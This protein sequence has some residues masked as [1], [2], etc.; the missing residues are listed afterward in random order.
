MHDNP[1]YPDL[2]E[3]VRHITKAAVNPVRL[4]RYKISVIS[5][6]CSPMARLIWR[7]KIS[8]PIKQAAVW[9]I[10]HH[11]QV[12]HFEEVRLVRLLRDRMVEEARRQGKT[13]EEANVVAQVAL[14]H[15]FLQMPYPA[16]HNGRWHS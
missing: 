11:I 14:C 2:R 12:H 16:P 8:P 15:E 6:P 10:L 3:R 4:R 1:G 5:S 7:C 13:A 9:E